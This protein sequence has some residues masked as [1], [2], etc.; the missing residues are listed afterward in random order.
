MFCFWFCNAKFVIFNNYVAFC[1][2]RKK[3]KKTK[4]IKV[5]TR[6]CFWFR[7]DQIMNFVE[8]Q[9]FPTLIICTVRRS[10]YLQSGFSSVSSGSR[11]FL[12]S[13]LPSLVQLCS[14]LSIKPLPERMLGSN[15]ISV[16]AC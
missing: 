14:L 16:F 5:Q 11:R 12:V 10:I 13:S 6:S 4:I 3:I 2:S 7:T 8:R 9:G 15:Q 1:L